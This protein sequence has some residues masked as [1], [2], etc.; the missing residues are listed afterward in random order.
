MQDKELYQ[1]LLG[2]NTPWYVAR[3]DLQLKQGEV[4]V[5]VEHGESRWTCPEC[6]EVCPLYDHAEERTWRHLDTMQFTTLLHARAPRVSCDDHGVRQVKLPWAEPKSR[7][8]LLFEAFAISVLQAVGVAGAQK[9]LG[10][11]WDE[12]WT[13]ERR[14]VERGLR[15]KAVRV[16]ELMGLDEKAYRR[17]KDSYMTIV[18]DLERGTVDWIGDDRKAETLVRYF[19]QFSAEQLAGIRGIA[20]DMWKGYKLAIRTKVP[21]PDRKMIYDRFHVM[22]EIN[23]AVDMVRKREHRSLTAADDERLKGTKYLWLHARE[24]VPRKHRRW[25]AALKRA[26][27]KTARAWAIKEDLRHFW[28]RATETTA[29][30][31]WKA[32]Y[33]WASHSRLMPIILAARKL[34]RHAHALLNYFRCRITNAYAEGMNGR[35]ETLKRLARGYRNLENFKIAIFFHCGGL[36]LLPAT[37]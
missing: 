9:V 22:R 14:A 34:H 4:H 29:I 21:D 35:I 28:N 5:W 27:L 2:L 19:E 24:N 7:F 36:D 37:H 30:R 33:F 6:S 16:P 26:S 20:M 32:W 23:D 11:S 3:V 1:A 13:I 10:L 8:T 15:R 25:F 17:G 12:A 31:F 18:S